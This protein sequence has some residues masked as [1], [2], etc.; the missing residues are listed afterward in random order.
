MAQTPEVKWAPTSFQEARTLVDLARTGAP[1]LGSQLAR[2]L[3]D[4]SRSA[5]ANGGPNGLGGLRCPSPPGEDGL[6]R[7]GLDASGR[8]QVEKCDPHGE[9]KPA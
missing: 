8:P 1:P 3:P 9:W 2:V 6:C 5:R 7:V 4:M